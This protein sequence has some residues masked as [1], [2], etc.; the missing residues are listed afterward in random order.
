MPRTVTIRSLPEA[1]SV[2]EEMQGQDGDWG[3]D[4]RAAGRAAL[5][6]ILERQM[7]LRVDRHLEEMAARG[8]VDRR[9]GADTRWLLSELGRIELSVPRTRRFSPHPVVRAYA[10]RAAHIDRMIRACFVLELR[11]R[12]VASALRLVLGRRISAGTVSQVA[13]TLDAAVATFHCPVLV[14]LGLRPD[15][16]KEIIDYRPQVADTR[17]QARSAACRFAERRQGP[18]PKAVACLRADLDEL[19][20]CIRYKAVAA[21]KA[22]R[23]TN[24]I[25]SKFR[26]VRRR[27]RPMGALQDRTSMDRI[28]FAVFTHENSTPGGPTL[29]SLTQNI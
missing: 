11:I 15:G 21:R 28:L 23:T 9:N 13:K 6:E 20:T 17:P 24:A 29:F 26:E 5:V 2:I 4:Y 10:R 14:A 19:L 7:A 25:E 16:K 22:V 3:E 1:F 8:A 18:H 12:K 27:T